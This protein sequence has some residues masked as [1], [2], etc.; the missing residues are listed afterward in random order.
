MRCHDTHTR[1]PTL[2]FWTE[3]DGVVG[4][5]HCK[6]CACPCCLWSVHDGASVKARV[7]E[8]GCVE[9]LF[10]E[11]VGTKCDYV[12]FVWPIFVG[13][14]A[15]IQHQCMKDCGNH[16]ADY[17]ILP[18]FCPV[19]LHPLELLPRLRDRLPGQCLRVAS[20]TPQML[21]Q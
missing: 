7:H 18:D 1:L 5:Y 17:R 16:F 2:N 12:S 9:T 19:N 8:A 3:A 10:S 6:H 13:L 4:G 20:G 14:P 21:A 15:T 11:N